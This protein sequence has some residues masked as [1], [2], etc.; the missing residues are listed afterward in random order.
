[1]QFARDGATTFNYDDATF[2]YDDAARRPVAG[3]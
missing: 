2:N 1:M 3:V